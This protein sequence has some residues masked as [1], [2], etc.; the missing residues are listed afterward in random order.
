[1]LTL[2][3]GLPP[4]N[5]YSF[6]GQV[7]TMIREIQSVYALIRGGG[8]GQW[9]ESPVESAVQI[10]DTMEYQAKIGLFSPPYPTA[11][12]T[13]RATKP[14]CTTNTKN[15]SAADS[16]S[17]SINRVH[18]SAAEFEGRIEFND[19]SFAYPNKPSAHV[20]EGLSLTIE[21]EPV[22]SLDVPFVLTYTLSFPPS[23]S[24]PLSS[25]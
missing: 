4:G 1:M 11:C 22:F 10:I 18:P 3:Q 9:D 8:Q 15:Q 20:L 23:P 17:A 24:L 16:R 2:P 12:A 21:V 19:V 5:L 25:L 14:A 7:E 6:N 13:T